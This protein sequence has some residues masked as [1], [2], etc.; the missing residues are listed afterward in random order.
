L[1]VVLYHIIYLILAL[2]EAPNRFDCQNEAFL[3]IQIITSI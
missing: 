2:R 3:Q 1:K